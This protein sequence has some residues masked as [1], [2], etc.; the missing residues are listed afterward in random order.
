V[1]YSVESIEQWIRNSE[2][3]DAPEPRPKVSAIRPKTKLVKPTAVA[4]SN[5][6]K[7][8]KRTPAKSSQPKSTVNL[9]K[10]SV[11]D[12]RQSTPEREEERPSPFQLLLKGIGIDRN[13]L[14]PLTNGELRRIAEVDVPTFHGW[15]YLGRQMPEEALE[16]LRQHFRKLTSKMG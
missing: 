1:R 14:G 6:E 3:T 9:R 10:S 15:M 4:M 16:K 8:A 11:A 5:E 7:P 13:D 12:H 2:S